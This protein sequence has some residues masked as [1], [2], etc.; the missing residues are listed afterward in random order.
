MERGDGLPG[1]LRI[2]LRLQLRDQAAGAQNLEQVRW[3]RLERYRRAG[4]QED[5]P[6]FEVHG[7]R[8]ALPDALVQPGALNHGEAD[9]DRVP[10]ENPRERVRDDA[11][12]ADT[13][14]RDDGLLAARAAAEVARRDD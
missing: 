12:D 13:L 9:V 8:I 7:D 14:Q 6:R 4:V 2:E 3:D 11:R 5:L 10:V 1:P